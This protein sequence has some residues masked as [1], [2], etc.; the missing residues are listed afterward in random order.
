[1]MQTQ[2]NIV[3]AL[4]A[5]SA[6]MLTLGRDDLACYA[7]DIRLRRDI[8]ERRKKR[9]EKDELLVAKAPPPK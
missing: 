6:D 9:L 1:M 2:K 7:L 4:S 5:S 8:R 3:R